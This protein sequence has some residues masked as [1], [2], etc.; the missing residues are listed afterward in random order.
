MDR[1]QFLQLSALLAA[2]A[3]TGSCA[4]LTPRYTIPEPFTRPGEKLL[5]TRASVV[6]VVR[7]QVLGGHA[8]LVQNGRI[9][10]LF[11]PEAERPSGADREL[12]LQGAHV[13]P[14]II[15]AHC[16]MSL[17]GGIGFGP[18]MLL[19]YR[20]QL[21]RNAEEC[22]KHG[23]TT[24]RDM[25]AMGD[26]LDEL[27]DKIDRR[28]ILGPRIHWCRALDVDDGY[29]DRM[30]YF[31]KKRF[32]KAVQSPEEGEQ[33]VREAADQGVDFIKLFQQPR[34]LYL[35]G[36]E[37]PVMNRDT[38]RAVQ[39]EADRSGKYVALHHTTLDGLTNGLFAG[40]RSL[41]HM[42]T[43]RTVPDDMVRQ[44][45]DGDHTVIPTAT[46]AFALAYDRRGDP[47]WGKG[48]C[49]RI[50]EERPRYMPDLIREFC[51]PELVSSTLRFFHRLCDP[52]SFE[53]WHLMPWPDPTTMNAAAS[54]G[55]VN[56]D[57][58]YRAG[59]SFGCGNDGGVPLI[60]PGAMY[61]EMRLLEEQGMKTADILRMATVNN[62]RLLRR[63][64]LGAV[65][66]GK[67]AD[68]AIFRE[69]PLE[70]VRN[71][72]RPEFVFQEGRLVVRNA[73][74]ERCPVPG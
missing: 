53:S 42:S 65:E 19:A 31:K 72:A 43:D 2:G 21:E 40:V 50:E 6:D 35:P 73:G 37:L 10:A 38:L 74:Q 32:W 17:P 68:L 20:R 15:N 57:E 56:T 1:R 39:Q 58:L 29:T 48:L 66:A 13:L 28:E 22:V 34:E 7:G 70:T 52:D 61:V 12:D 3:A 67:T 45:L 71:L 46:V 24:V 25:L 55:A 14:G 33:A 30:V 63:G 49:V 5:L 51:E 18:G 60:F 9:L 64:D 4:E 8:I 59:V 44:L 41:E 11:P 47:N 54:E 27:R 62:A 16:H 69:N 23:V 36:K 26:F